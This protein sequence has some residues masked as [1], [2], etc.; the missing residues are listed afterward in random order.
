MKYHLFLAGKINLA[1]SLFKKTIC[2]LV[3]L[4]VVNSLASWAQSSDS[5]YYVYRNTGE[6]VFAIPDSL[7]KSYKKTSYYYR[8]NLVNDSVLSFYHRDID[9]ISRAL[10]E[11]P[12]F[13]SFKI[14]NKY[15]SDLDNDVYCV[16]SGNKIYGDMGNMLGKDLRPSFETDRTATVFVDTIK[17]Q[18]RV[19]RVRFD[20][21]VSYVVSDG[22]PGMVLDR[23][24]VKAV[25]N[26]DTLAEVALDIEQLYTNAPTTTSHV[27][28]NVLDN[29]P[30]TFFHCTGSADSG[31]YEVLPLDSCPYIDITLREGLQKFAFYYMTRG[32]TD[33]R[34]PLAFD[35]H[36]SNDYKAWKL[37]DSFDV[38]DGIPATGTNATF[39]SPIMDAG[40]SY[41]YIRVEM[42][43]SNYKNYL[44]L[45]ELKI[46]EPY[47]D[48]TPIKEDYYQFFTRPIGREYKVN[49]TF[50]ADTAGVPRVDVD[51]DG[52]ATITSRDYWL[53]AK[54]RLTGNGMYES[55]EDSIQIKGRGNSS[56]GWR[57]KPYTIKFAEKTKLCGLRKG[58]RWNLMSNYQDVTEMMNATVFKAGRIMGAPYQPHSIPIELYVNGS[59]YGCY[60][61]TEHVG[62]HN[63]CVDEDDFSQLLELDTYFDETYKFTSMFY[64]LPVNIKNP[65]PSEEGCPQTFYEIQ[66]EWNEFEDI[67]R[68][69]KDLTDVFSVDSFATFM[70][71]NDL[72]GNTELNHPKST[73]LYKPT[74]T[75]RYIFGPGWDF[76][77]GFGYQMKGSYFQMHE[78]KTI[79]AFS[80]LG[81]TFFNAL[82][83]HEQIITAY[84]K[85]WMKF[86]NNNGIEELINWMDD[87]Y[88]YAQP[89]YEHSA[90][91]GW[92]KTSYA[93][94]FE[95]FKTWL[96]QRVEY[97]ESNLTVPTGVDDILWSEVDDNSDSNNAIKVYVTNGVLCVESA[98]QT[99]LKIY[100]ADGSVAGEL[101]V[102]EGENVYPLAP[103]GLI[104]ING[105]KV[106]LKPIQ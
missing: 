58:K 32:D 7:V 64:N 77:W 73:F 79:G 16:I 17:Q 106:Y 88:A 97:I 105:Q 21:E 81:T 104:I 14:N 92:S 83:K 5:V 23:R 67:L 99:T 50:R 44:N 89:S 103:R 42:T 98:I 63:N 37:V 55:V 34:Q 35:I 27:L 40:A 39:L 8:F 94:Y 75:T 46:Y 74:G 47:D 56:W 85:L 11:F 60:T 84:Y 93:A 15:N 29:N 54:F 65:D 102:A 62:I 66:D 13:T 90:Q 30:S 72:C 45:A 24:F 76:D 71:M 18:T 31:T 52:G 87:Y 22:T 70:F 25:N 4:F 12:K 61:L 86:L 2:L 96:K 80:G 68:R 1:S 9:S 41:K 36:V 59:Y 6:G 53:K 28:A 78:Y 43:K 69:K 95:Q 101:L 49:L 33:E 10:K 19:S 91:Y 57:N 26:K 48:G 20:K 3:L 100:R 38:N 82:L 51:I